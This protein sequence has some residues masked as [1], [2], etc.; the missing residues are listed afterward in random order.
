[1]S[2]P[3]VGCK[4]WYTP[5]DFTNTDLL[6]LDVD[7]PWLYE[8]SGGI[9]RDTGKWML[10]YDKKSMNESWTLAKKLYRKGRLEGVVSMKCSTMYENA[11]ASGSD[12]VIILYCSD[13]SNAESILSVGKR[14]LEAFCYKG[15]EY[16][17]YKTDAQTRE[18]TRATGQLKNYTYRLFNP[19]Y[20]IYT[21]NCPSRRIR[22]MM[23]AASTKEGYCE[24]GRKEEEGSYGCS[25]YPSCKNDSGDDGFY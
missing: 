4:E 3:K 11:R 15:K 19:L 7:F 12:G 1:M 18:G 16:I 22:E 20:K 2:K 24:C 10:F 25:S 9:H 5:E 14:I 6:P 13:S 8:S 23:K 21:N 17:Y